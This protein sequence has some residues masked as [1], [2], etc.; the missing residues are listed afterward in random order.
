MEKLVRQPLYYY[1]NP[2][3]WPMWAGLGFL[4]VVFMLPLSWQFGIGRM[5]GR[6]A[7]RIAV[8]RRSI[9]R[10]N[11]ELCFPEMLTDARNKLVHE[12]F[13]ALGIS[14]IE[15][16][17]GRWATDDYLESITTITGAEHIQNAI[18]AG[19]GVILLSAHFTSLE[20]SGR[21]LGTH[22]PPFDAVYRRFRSDFTTEIMLSNREIAARRVIEKNDIK[23][24]VR[25]LREGVPVWYAPDQSYHLKQ[26]ALLPFFGV[27]AM[28]NTATGTLAKLGKA[29]AVPFFPRRLANGRYELTLLPAIAAWPSGDT[30]EDTRQYTALLEQHIKNCPEQYYWVHRKFKNRPDSLADVYADFTSV[31]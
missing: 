10:R 5:I 13:E 19:Y 4:R 29:K 6:I 25:S 20:V 2:K 21:V 30:E 3:Y 15:L 18:D 8:E 7:H 14:L 9:A 17:L 22:C 27:P 16:G 11:I 26:S 28:T 12:H 1:W 31:K 24:M 23:R